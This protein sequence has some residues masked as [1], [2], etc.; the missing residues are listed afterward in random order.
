MDIEKLKDKLGDETFAALKGYVEDLTGQRDAARSESIDKRKALKAEV[1]TL[2]AFRAKAL[3]KLGIGDDDDIDALP[4][5]KGQAD[6][7]KQFDQQ[8][9]RLTRERDE[10]LAAKTETDGK[11]RG[12]QQKATL[13]EALSKHQF[14]ARDLVEAYVAPRLVWE[15]D[16]VLFKADDGKLVAVADGVAGLAKSRPELLQPTGTGGAGARTTGG[17][18]GGTTKG[19]FGGDRGARTA[20]IAA[21]FPDLAPG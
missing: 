10:A 9:K 15:G 12:S 2:K 18:G 17:G 20:A 14:L 6:A 19:D 7:A 16:E 21:R 1:D 11:L 13:A 5:A 8:I 4:D 3:E